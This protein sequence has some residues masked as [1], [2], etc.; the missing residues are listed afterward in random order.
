ML[1]SALCLLDDIPSRSFLKTHLKA[2][3]EANLTAS[4]YKGFDH[5]TGIAAGQ[6]L[7]GVVVPSWVCMSTITSFFRILV[8]P[9]KEWRFF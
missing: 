9:T 3:L 6:G 2:K 8:T 1:S 4:G 7:E 5:E